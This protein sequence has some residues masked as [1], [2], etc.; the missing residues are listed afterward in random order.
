MGP[1][2]ILFTGHLLDRID[3]T[4][5]RFPYRLIREVKTLIEIEVEQIM[6]RGIPSMAVSSLAAGGDMLFASEMVRRHVPLSVFLPFEKD[7]FLADSV[8]YL[9][10]LPSEDPKEWEDHFHENISKASQVIVTHS[11]GL[12][13]EEAYSV[14]NQAMLAFALNLTKN[15]PSKIMALALI[16]NTSEIKKGG[17]AD[18]VNQLESTG[19]N[20]KKIWPGRTNKLYC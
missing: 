4:S 11:N 8:K 14:C 3:R 19:I 5:A 9:K 1:S 6:K 18:F 16:Q 20:V 17:A 2:I 10:D 15:H 12:S 7:R 13:P